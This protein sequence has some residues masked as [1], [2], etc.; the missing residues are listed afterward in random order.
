MAMASFVTRGSRGRRQPRFRRQGFKGA[1]AAPHFR[2]LVGDGRIFFFVDEV[3]KSSGLKMTSTWMTWT[4]LMTTLF[5]A[6]L[7]GQNFESFKNSRNHLFIKSF[8]ATRRKIL[9]SSTTFPFIILKHPILR[10][11]SYIMRYI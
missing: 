11:V 7:S 8:F 10:S 3:D 2:R 5:A 6:I 9:S 1:R 4:T